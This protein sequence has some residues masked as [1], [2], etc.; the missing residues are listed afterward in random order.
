[1]GG[2]LRIPPSPPEIADA[3]EQHKRLSFFNVSRYNEIQWNQVSL[4]S[5]LP[6]LNYG[7]MTEMAEGARLEI[8]C[9]VTGTEGS[10]PSLSASQLIQTKQALF[11]KGNSR[12]FFYVLSCPR[13]KI[14][15]TDL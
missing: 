10:N 8:V 9:A 5:T 15:T 4:T 11:S 3:F 1:M 13:E 7:E 14:S 2:S 6:C 12:C